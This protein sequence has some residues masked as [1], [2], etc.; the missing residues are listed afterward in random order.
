MMKVEARFDKKRGY[1]EVSHSGVYNS[2]MQDGQLTSVLENLEEGQHCTKLLFDGRDMVIDC[3]LSKIF[4]SGEHFDRVGLDHRYQIA[5]LYN[6]HEDKI[7]FLELVIQNRGHNVRAFRDEKEAI[8]WLTGAAE[9][10]NYSST[11]PLTSLSPHPAA[12]L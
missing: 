12:T 9:P 4:F 6:E 1:I 11:E 7:K 10:K 2:F 5:I 8:D 3:Q